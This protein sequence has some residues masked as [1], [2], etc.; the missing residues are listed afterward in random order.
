MFLNFTAFN[1]FILNATNNYKNKVNPLNS[2]S[3]FSNNTHRDMI[4][5]SISTTDYYYY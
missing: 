1:S 3:G 2:V 4:S 5:F